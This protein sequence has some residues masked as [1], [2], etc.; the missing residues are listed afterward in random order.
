MELYGKNVLKA[1]LDA[2]AKKGRLPHA[3]LFS[4]SVGSGRK[5][6]A[7]YA[8]ELFLCGAPPCGKC[9]VCRSIENN[10]HPDIKFVKEA[11]GEKYNINGVREALADIA[12]LPNNGE[13][14][15]YI[16][17]NF[18]G[19]TDKVQNHLLKIIEEPAPFVKFIF[20]CES[21]NT[22]LETILSRVAVYEIPPAPISECVR[23]LTDNGCG[24]EKAQSL[25]ELYGGNIGKCRESSDGAQDESM[26]AAKKAAAALTSMNRLEVCA[27]LSSRLG[28]NDFAELLPLLSEI[29]RS[30]LSIR[31]GAAAEGLAA[32]ESKTL[33]A[34]FSEEQLLAMLDAI[35][36]IT[37]GLVLNPNIA[38]TAAQLSAKLF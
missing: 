28:R 33:A 1:Q 8:A 7:K 4:G 22:I 21:S 15:L 38:L 31:C 5:T 32:K 19:V 13:L 10:S 11:C 12:V 9:A 20:T 26:A 17:E 18:D 6:M 37:D 29:I 35:F 3:L 25:A 23:F 2:A 30:A 16:F 36:D 27:A 14:K 24:K 34:V